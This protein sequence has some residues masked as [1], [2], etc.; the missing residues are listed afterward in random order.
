MAKIFQ[1]FLRP[2]GLAV[3]S[4]FPSSC[5]YYKQKSSEAKKKKKKKKRKKGRGETENSLFVNYKAHDVYFVL[6]LG[7]SS[8]KD[9]LLNYPQCL[10]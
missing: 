4:C 9:L 2:N 1:G 8:I 10:W 7:L 3:F 5:Q 6:R